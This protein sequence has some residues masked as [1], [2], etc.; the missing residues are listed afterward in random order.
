MNL[1]SMFKLEYNLYFYNLCDMI[2]SESKNKF[3]NSHSVYIPH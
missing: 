2:T 1:V 3:S